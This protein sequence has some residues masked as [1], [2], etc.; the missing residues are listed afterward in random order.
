M[1]NEDRATRFAERIKVWG[2]M[3]LVVSSVI[4]L[5]T[6]FVVRAVTREVRED[7]KAT[8]ME[9]RQITQTNRAQAT[10][11]SIRFERVMEVVELAVVAIVEPVGSDDQRGAVAELRRRRH[12]TPK[13]GD[14]R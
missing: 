1:N 13:P 7:I 11:D 6:G 14:L 12:V 5:T 2:S 8:R 3:V 9:M 4:T 10:A